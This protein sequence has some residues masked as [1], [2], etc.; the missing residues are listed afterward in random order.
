[1]LVSSIFL[2]YHTYYI[3]FLILYLEEF[4]HFGF[5]FYAPA[6]KE[7]RHIVLPV[8]VCPSVF[9]SQ[10]LPA[11]LAI[12]CNFKTFMGSWCLTNTSI[13]FL[14]PLTEGQR[15]IV[16]ALCPSCVRSSVRA[17]VNFFF[18]KLL[19]RNY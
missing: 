14:A 9:L 6:W 18:K 15:A 7:H 11:N 17:S 2:F 13:L 8:S 19:L 16:M 3:F 12:P 4:H 5:I 1:M 10:T